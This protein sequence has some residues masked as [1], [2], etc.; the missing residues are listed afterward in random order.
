VL[1]KPIKDLVIKFL[2]K[3]DLTQV[4]GLSSDAEV[5][6]LEELNVE[7]TLLALQPI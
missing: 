3:G 4:V 7:V 6:P 5:V 2:F 1:L